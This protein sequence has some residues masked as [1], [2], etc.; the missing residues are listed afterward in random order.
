MY[1]IWLVLNILWEM[2]LGIWLV[3]AGALLIWSAIMVTALRRR[4]ARWRASLRW[5]LLAA[6]AV[7]AV[8]T[9][10]LPGVSKSSLAEMGYWVDWVNLVAVA[11]GFGAVAAAFVWPIAAIRVGSR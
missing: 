4:G 5:A 2:A 3:V 8:A 10:V 9:L 11:A 7:T 6:L 1:E